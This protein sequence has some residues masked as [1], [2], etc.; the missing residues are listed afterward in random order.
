MNPGDS[1][2]MWAGEVNTVLT[3]LE[4]P[5]RKD[6]QA[7]AHKIAVMFHDAWLEQHDGNEEQAKRAMALMFGSNGGNKQAL[8]KAFAE[9]FGAPIARTVVFL[10]SPH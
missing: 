9:H 7:L 5:L 1:D 6:V 2:A 3:R 10:L 4:K 8:V